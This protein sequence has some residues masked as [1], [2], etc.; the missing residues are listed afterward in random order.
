[1]PA[2]LIIKQTPKGLKLIPFS[3]TR[4][5]GMGLKLSSSHPNAHR[6]REVM[7]LVM[8]PVRIMVQNGGRPDIKAAY[9]QA[10]GLYGKAAFKDCTLLPATAKLPA[11]LLIKDAN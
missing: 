2:I 9:A 1:M 11:R 8:K 10:E 5:D 6:V 4:P 3:E 7:D